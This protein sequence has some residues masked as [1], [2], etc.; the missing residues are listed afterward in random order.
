MS[1]E[2]RNPRSKG[3]DQMAPTDLAAL[4][5]GENRYAVEAVLLATDEL[6]QAMQWCAAA[7]QAGGR[8]IYAGAG[9]S[10]RIA[11][12]D[13]AE[14][15]PTFGVD[16]NR[17]VALV[18]GSATDRAQEGAEDDRSAAAADFASLEPKTIDIVIGFSASGT[19]P[20]VL[21]IMESANA[22]GNKTVGIANNPGAPLLELADLG[23]L[24]D[25]GPEVLA[26]STRLKAGTAQK[27]ALNTISTG[28]MVLAGRVIGNEMSHMTPNN[29]KLR[30]RAIGIVATA[31]GVAEEAAVARL[32]ICD[33]NLP[34]ALK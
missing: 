23:I 27:I 12:A 10:A 5:A 13:A 9:T 34:E 17:F 28:A 30:Q 14:M 20:Y 29:D 18:A 32:E 15:P 33:W 4:I 11:A 31:L 21:A 24:L 25:T 16:P 7:F 22:S 2:D 19:T 1:T 8:V 6:A 3:L 26:G